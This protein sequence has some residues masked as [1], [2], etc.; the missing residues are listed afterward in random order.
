MEE[1]E[2]LLGSDTIFHLAPRFPAEPALKLQDRARSLP[3]AA[4]HQGPGSAPLS[5]A[6]PTTRDNKEDHV[7]ADYWPHCML[8][9][10]EAGWSFTESADS[11]PMIH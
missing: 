11:P 7:G 3:P 9:W 1:T 6:S 10:Q 2:G 8:G 5:S 4:G